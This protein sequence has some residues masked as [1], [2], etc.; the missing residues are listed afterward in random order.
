MNV[1]K[2]FW[3]LFF[4]NL[5]NYIDRQVLFSVFPLIQDELAISDFHIKL[6]GEFSKARTKFAK[7]KNATKE[8]K[9]QFVASFDW[10]RMTKQDDAVWGEIF[11]HLDN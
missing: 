1:R 11:A 5:F 8:E 4:L 2:L 10:E 7:K 9:A 3:I 6:L